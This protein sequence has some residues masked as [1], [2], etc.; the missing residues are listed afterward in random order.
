MS[1]TR[2]WIWRIACVGLT[3]AALLGANQAILALRE[4]GWVDDYTYRVMMLCGINVLLAVSL[5]LINGITGQ[6]SIGH[7]GFQGVGAYASAAL[8]VFVL[9]PWLQQRGWQDSGLAHTL[10]LTAAIAF[11]GTAAG[12]AGLVVGIPSLRLRGDYLAIATLGFGEIIRVIILNIEQVG[13]AR[14]FSGIPLVTTF[15]GLYLMVVL[16]LA[17]SRNLLVSSQGL[18][19]L[20]VRDDEV[21][22]EAVGVNTTRI[23]VIAFVLGAAFAGVAGALYAH[24]DGYLNPDNFR[25]DQSIIILTMVVL[26]GQGSITGSVVSAMLLTIVLE[27]LRF[28]PTIT[29]GGRSF[30]PSEL[31]MVF[32]SIMLILLMLWRPKGL[33][34]QR[35]FGWYVL[36]QYW[37][38]FRA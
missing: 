6:F 20:A 32:F 4:T 30:A 7:A 8:T 18:A 22:A 19:F 10:M 3:L 25:L 13:G 28:L 24:F 16:L 17:L 23:K 9:L 15:S 1:V 38:L 35:E 2:Y 36:R 37:R 5:N 21:A 26:G 34:G 29:L 12:I 27:W 33:L 31:R 11:G 14:G